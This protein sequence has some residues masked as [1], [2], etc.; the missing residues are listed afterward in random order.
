MIVQTNGG[1]F[2]VK[3][4]SQI[5]DKVVLI[6]KKLRSDQRYAIWHV[7]KLSSVTMLEKT[8]MLETLCVWE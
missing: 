1:V 2:S 3:A 5:T 7:V 8:K 4:K 6:I